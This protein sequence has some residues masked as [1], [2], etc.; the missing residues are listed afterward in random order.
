MHAS[1]PSRDFEVVVWRKGGEA[2][3]IRCH[4]DG[5]VRELRQRYMTTQPAYAFSRC[6]LYLRCDDYTSLLGEDTHLSRM[7]KRE[8]WS[9]IGQEHWGDKV[10]HDLSTETKWPHTA[11]VGDVLQS[12]KALH[13]KSGHHLEFVMCGID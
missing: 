4:S 6:Q 11:T 3:T 2:T 8:C 10:G 7:G 9:L 1:M 5:Y 12:M 13:R